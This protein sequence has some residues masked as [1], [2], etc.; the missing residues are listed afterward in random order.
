MAYRPERGWGF[1]HTEAGPS[2]TANEMKICVAELPNLKRTEPTR[3]A[4]H[5]ALLA[6]IY[7]SFCVLIFKLFKIPVNQWSLSTAVL[8]G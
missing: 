3:E 7:V 4:N 6:L 1:S 5:G 8:G 2:I